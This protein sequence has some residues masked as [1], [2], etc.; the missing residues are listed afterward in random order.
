MNS[1][2]EPRGEALLG[3]SCYDKIM[4]YT[5]KSFRVVG[6]Q[7]KIIEISLHFFVEVR[8]QVKKVVCHLSPREK[9]LLVVADEALR[10]LGYR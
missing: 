5:I 6:E 8:V 10:G 2:D 4:V 7:N 9:H 1:V 3:Y